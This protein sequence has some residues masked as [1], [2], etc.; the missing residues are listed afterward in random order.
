LLLCLRTLTVSVTDEV[1]KS[2]IDVRASHAQ[3]LK[4]VGRLMINCDLNPRCISVSTLTWCKCT[5]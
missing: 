1:R 5:Q 2:M 4:T 3:A